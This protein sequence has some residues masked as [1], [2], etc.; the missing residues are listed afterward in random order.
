ML[1]AMTKPNK[2]GIRKMKKA[3][4]YLMV[5]IPFA[6][7]IGKVVISE[8]LV[9]TFKMISFVAVFAGL[10]IGGVYLIKKDDN[11]E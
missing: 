9:E 5:S 2:R 6:L 4:G 10:L 7:V 1:S 11:D 3:L 8:G